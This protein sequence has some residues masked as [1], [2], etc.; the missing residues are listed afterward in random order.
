[1]VRCRL[2]LSALDRCCCC[3]SCHWAPH[4]AKLLLPLL[5]P[6]PASSTCQLQN[7]E[8]PQDGRLHIIAAADCPSTAFPWR[9]PLLLLLPLLQIKRAAQSHLPAAGW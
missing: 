7:G 3:A 5:Q 2:S 4:I 9:K 1:M 6:K 8:V